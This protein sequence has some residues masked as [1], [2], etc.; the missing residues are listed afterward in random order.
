MNLKWLVMLL[1][2]FFLSCE[3]SE[4]ENQ[5]WNRGMERFGRVLGSPVVDWSCSL[6]CTIRLKDGRVF[7]AHCHTVGWHNEIYCQL[8]LGQ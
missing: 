2:A 7:P 1:A 8:A 3:S 6:S 5:R 4:E